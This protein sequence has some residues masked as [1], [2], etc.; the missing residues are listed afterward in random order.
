MNNIYR[1]RMITALFAVILIL[2]GCGM[3]KESE[4]LKVAFQ[5]L[6]SL[7]YEK[8]LVSFEQA[9]QEGTTNQRVLE[10]GL[11]IA[12]LGLGQYDEAI[13]HF[14]ESISLSDGRVQDIDYDINYHLAEAYFEKG[15]FDRALEIY[16]AIIELKP[17]DIVAN[18]QKGVV[19]IRLEQKDNACVQFD[20]VTEIEPE[21]NDLVVAI[22]KELS[23]AGYEEEGKV[24]IQ[25]VLEAKE[26][27]LTELEKGKLYYYLKDYENARQALERIAKKDQETILMLGK[28]HEALGDLEYAITVYQSAL[29]REKDSVIYNQL[30]LCHMELGEYD[31][32]LI[33]IESAL[34][35]EEATN[36]QDLL[37]NEVIIH[38]YLLDFDKATVLMEAYLEKYPNDEGAI[39]E[40]EFL[41]TR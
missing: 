36:L 19:L 31:D 10:R 14:N 28:T 24:Y 40:Y 30:A 18:F 20:K 9:T 16:N 35:M 7:E 33:Q 26:E 2:V 21:D 27:E 32:A 8:A 15:E 5:H 23:E 29:A 37:F 4:Y 13:Q 39:L 22:F 34:A 38:E 1:F 25:A 17:K 6:E 3:Q 41:S 11:G 12:Y